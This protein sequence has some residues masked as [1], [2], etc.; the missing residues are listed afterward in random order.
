M[1]RPSMRAVAV[2]VVATCA[3]SWRTGATSDRSRPAG[4]APETASAAAVSAFALPWY[5]VNAGG[6]MGSSSASYKMSQ[7]VGQSVIG[8]SASSSYTLGI[9]FWYG[10]G[11]QAGCPITRTG[12]VNV[13]G[14]ITSADI[15]GLVNY[16]FKG[17]AQPLPCVASGDVNCS[18]AVTSADIISLVNYVFKAGP[19]PCDACTSP[20]AAG[21]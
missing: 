13:S 10:V 9:G 2:L 17:G 6:A 1:R 16:V 4:S 18:G 19:S 15:I 7:S 12:D 11:A 5:S 14:T 3:L 21:C 8:R 20:L